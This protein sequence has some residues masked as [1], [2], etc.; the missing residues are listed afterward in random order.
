MRTFQQV[1]SVLASTTSGLY[2]K[3]AEFSSVQVPHKI[4][5]FMQL[6]KRNYQVFE[7]YSAVKES[8]K[9]I[10]ISWWIHYSIDFIIYLTREAFYLDDSE[11][12]KQLE[13]I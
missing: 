8:V 11:T 6:Y 3:P 9:I 12:L 2:T 5:I 13:E 1:P 4:A 10:V 7:R